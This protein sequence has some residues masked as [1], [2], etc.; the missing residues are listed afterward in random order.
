MTT[1][2]INQNIVMQIAVQNDGVKY[3]AQRMK[4]V[5]EG[6]YADF[7]FEEELENLNKLSRDGKITPIERIYKREEIIVEGLIREF[8]GGEVMVLDGRK[9]K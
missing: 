7:Y 8:Y 9:N 1:P 3:I 4:D 6:Y 5:P 2:I